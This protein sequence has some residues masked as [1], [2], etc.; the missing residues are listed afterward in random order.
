VETTPGG[1]YTQLSAW[2]RI[3]AANGWHAERVALDAG[4]GVVATQLLVRKLGPTR[5]SVAYAPRG[6]FGS[7]LD[8]GVDEITATLRAAGRGARATSVTIEPPVRSGDPLVGRLM[9]AG[10]RSAPPIQPDR[11]RLVDLRRDEDMLWSDLRKKW[12]QYVSKA[13]R[14]GVT[15]EDAGAAGLDDFYVIYVETAR[16]A[17]FVHRSR[18]A[19]SRVFEA[20][21]AHDRARLL[22][23][24]DKDG[25]A[26]AALM[27]LHC[28]STV[29]E[30]Y[31][32]MT[33]AGAAS[34][35]NY[36]LKWEA[37]RTSRERGFETYDM[38]GLA[39]P[40][41]EQFK[42]GFGGEEVRYAGA[43]EI[44]L[45]RPVHV[46]LGLARRV[47]VARARR[48]HGVAGAGDAT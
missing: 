25:R 32:G 19:Y 37:I 24:R 23:A 28:G 12:R 14:E 40:G 48:R 39:H 16:R 27:L 8:G 26:S 10:W 36:L 11:S 6:P 45:N 1:S 35:A 3:K 13:R 38:W 9:T 17:G 29:I 22:L 2:A 21:A 15:I 42:A 44:V 30:P 41:I 47:L 20:F 5:W 43:F 7:G 34:R 33:D 18:S 46:A 4:A 31:G